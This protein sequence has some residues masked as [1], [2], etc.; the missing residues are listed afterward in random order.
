MTIHT[1][2]FK[3][4][5]PRNF[6]I[7]CLLA[8]G[9]IFAGC[10][11]N[12]ETKEKAATEPTA[13]PLDSLNFHAEAASL[14]QVNLSWNKIRRATGY[15]ISREEYKNDGD[16]P[17]EM[18]ANSRTILA[19]L[20]PKDISYQ[21]TTVKKETHYRY[22][23]QAYCEYDEL[24]ETEYEADKLEPV[25]VEGA[26]V[27][28]ALEDADWKTNTEEQRATS[29]SSITIEVGLNSNWSEKIAPEGI[30]IYRGTSF[31]TIQKLTELPITQE[32]C[33]DDY[34]TGIRYVD[35]NVTAGETYFYQ[36]KS[37]KVLDGTRVYGTPTV[38]LKKTAVLPEGDYSMEFE[39]K[40]G[41]S[42]S[43]EISLQ[44]NIKGNAKLQFISNQFNG[45]V[46]Y[47]YQNKDG[48]YHSVSMHLKSYKKE[49]TN[50][51]AY[52]GQTLYLKEEEQISLCFVPN[53]GET[54]VFPDENMK[55]AEILLLAEYNNL[56]RNLH[57]DLKQNQ[58]FLTE[59]NSETDKPY[60][61]AETINASDVTKKGISQ[62]NFVAN[63]T[64]FGYG[65]FPSGF[66]ETGILFTPAYS[67]KNAITPD[68]VEI[69]RSEDNENFSLAEVVPYSEYG[70]IKYNDPRAIPGNTYYYKAR[71]YRTTDSGKVYGKFS[72][73]ITFYANYV[74]GKYKM[75]LAENQTESEDLENGQQQIVIGIYSYSSG[76]PTL[77]FDDSSVSCQ[78][79]GKEF[80]FVIKESSLDGIH[81]KKKSKKLGLSPKK[82]I[83]LKLEAKEHQKKYNYND[84]N[85]VLVST[86]SEFSCTYLDFTYY[87]A[88]DK[89]SYTV[90]SDG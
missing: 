44:S 48:S 76:N 1:I 17:G 37:Y 67:N 70:S 15:V 87:P 7:V 64:G 28:L 50:Q 5:N 38:Y 89:L 57:F 85:Q 4:V 34:N 23:I 77:S 55:S 3:N 51:T 41:K 42:P 74:G 36:A 10:S 33:L 61:L 47:I 71:N 73:T 14:K 20:S 25:L 90:S 82:T 16:E 86:D 45:L 21:D 19:K 56:E 62:N 22:I 43:L 30:E 29:P 78:I 69:Y 84:I 39:Q 88:D 49:S 9:I 83:Y 75:W 53:E 60:S 13:R 12:T 46:D 32:N 66:Y 72:N 52:Q 59:K 31:D 18:V 79:D 8:I 11:R 68:G 40:K 54:L 2:F 27:Q 35:E 26:M 6:L 80:P 63:V 24:D 58:V 65:D 81:W